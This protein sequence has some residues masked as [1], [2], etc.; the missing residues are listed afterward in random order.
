M[1]SAFFPEIFNIWP[2]DGPC[3][4]LFQKDIN[5]SY[6]PHSIMLQIIQHIVQFKEF[7]VNSTLI[8][9]H[10]S[11]WRKNHHHSLKTKE[12]SSTLQTH[13]LA[14]LAINSTKNSQLITLLKVSSCLKSLTLSWQVEIPSALY[15]AHDL[16]LGKLLIAPLWFSSI[17]LCHPVVQ[18]V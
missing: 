10:P 17:S 18:K 15:T 8:Y 11:K 7:F 4:T 14:L 6:R 9:L 3:E 2:N 13:C 5:L 1:S 12:K 16:F